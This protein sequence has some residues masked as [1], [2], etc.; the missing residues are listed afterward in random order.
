MKKRNRDDYPLN[1]T[2][3]VDDALMFLVEYMG[4]DDLESMWDDID[5]NDEIYIKNLI[6]PRVINMYDAISTGDRQIKSNLK[7]RGIEGLKYMISCDPTIAQGAWS[8]NYGSF[9]PPNDARN[10]FK[11]V[12][13]IILEI[14]PELR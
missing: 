12:L 5:G 10:L 9:P 8:N 1:V 6:R 14:D 7:R 11:W 2:S 3:K 13:E 4:N